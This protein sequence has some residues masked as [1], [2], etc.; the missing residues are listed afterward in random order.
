MRKLTSLVCVG[1]TRPLFAVPLWPL[2]V[3]LLSVAPLQAGIPV[4]CGATLNV[5]GAQYA[6]TGNLSCT[7]NPAVWITASDVHFN[8]A[9]FTLSGGGTGVGILISNVSGVHVNGGKVTGYSVG[10]K[11]DHVSE[12]HVNGMTVTGNTTGIQLLS[13]HDN[14]INGN[15]V[16]NNATLGI[17]L[18]DSNN[19]DF[20][21]NVVV[22]NNREERDGGFTLYNS[23]N[24]VITS[25]NV[26]NNGLVGIWLDPASS[27]NIIRSCIANGQPGAVPPN[28]TGIEVRGS[29]NLVQGNLANNN[30]YGIWLTFGAADNRVQSN[31]AVF[32]S[33]VD[34]RDDNPSCGTNLWKSN[35]FTTDSEPDPLKGPA[36]G[37]IR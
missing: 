22:N 14:H 29:G 10:I 28:R 12:S 37:C 11:L 17:E 30:H 26:S 20:N 36:A 32:N 34:L 23:D 31:T 3:L 5:V 9:G 4:T 18:R 35:I 7:A 19:N 8:L 33:I 6:L 27:G 2:I 21:T 16:S 1:C 25:N 13:S 15:Y 24:N